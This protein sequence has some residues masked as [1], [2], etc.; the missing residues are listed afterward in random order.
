MVALD[1]SMCRDISDY[2]AISIGESCPGL[3]YLNI[4]GLSRV[5]DKGSR[6]LC[7]KCWYLETLA[8]E[9]VFLLDDAAFRF[10]L[11]YDGR[12]AAEEN[13]LKYLVT[14]NLR[15]CVN[16]TDEGIQGL[17]ERCRKIETLILRGCDKITDK[18]LEYMTNPYDDNFPMCDSFK[19]LDVSF[20]T[21]ITSKG[22]LD[23]LPMCG[24]LEELRLSGMVSVDDNF[25]H[26]MCIKCGTIQRL[27]MQKCV[28]V[29]DAALCSMA[30]Y[31]WLEY[32]DITG[33]RRVTDDGL[34]V[35]TVSCNGIIR[36][37]LTGVHKLSSRT[38]NSVAR[39]CTVIQELELEKCPLVTEKSLDDLQ[40][41]WPHLRLKSDFVNSVE[42]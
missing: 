32:L 18:C 5:S 42:H 36:L 41:Q 8:M 21:G 25:L 15:D 3:K 30:D 10:D 6:A 7:A 11:S 28:F 31:L 1:V 20:C 19:V 29:S 34:E 4:T 16:I 38:V 22:V 13:M 35:L 2:G 37:F 17:S 26:E 27:S 24:I 9:D 33:C 39:N 12:L 23:I 40:T 14:L